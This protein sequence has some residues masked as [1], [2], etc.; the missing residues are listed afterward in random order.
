M[1]YLTMAFFPLL[2]YCNGF[3][4]NFVFILHEAFAYVVGKD[5]FVA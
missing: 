1:S 4:L 2:Q 5:E 3:I